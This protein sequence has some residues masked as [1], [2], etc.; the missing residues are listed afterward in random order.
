MCRPSGGTADEAG[1]GRRVR[2]V[3]ASA[4]LAATRVPKAGME[5]PRLRAL[6]TER[7]AERGARIEK[8]PLTADN[9]ARSLRRAN[10]TPSPILSAGVPP[11]LAPSRTDT[12]R[13]E[14]SAR[15]LSH[16]AIDFSCDQ[17]CFLILHPLSVAAMVRSCPHRIPPRPGF[18]D[19]LQTRC[20][21]ND[22][23]QRHTALESWI[24]PARGRTRLKV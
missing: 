24:G 2:C 7:L 16:D 21:W 23:G 20:L 14:G 10:W 19:G 22:R 13:A 8:Q 4:V 17:G 12:W 9:S 11:R 18:A 6:A 1:E 3:T 15:R 5:E